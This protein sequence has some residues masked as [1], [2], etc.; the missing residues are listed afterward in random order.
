MKESNV[1]TFPSHLNTNKR[2]MP[3]FSQL[4]QPAFSCG[5]HGS[6]NLWRV[7]LCDRG[8]ESENSALVELS[9]FDRVAGTLWGLC[10]SL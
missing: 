3:G 6:H 8:Q 7:P 9:K 5:S 4:L 10:C 1:Y 2:K